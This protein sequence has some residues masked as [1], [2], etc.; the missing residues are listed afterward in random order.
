MQRAPG[1]DV[2]GVPF[3]EEVRLAVWGKAKPSDD[4]NVRYDICGHAMQW[5]RFGMRDLDDV[6]GSRGWE[7]DHI[8]PVEKAGSDDPANL[9]ALW[10]H[11]NQAKGDRFPWSCEMMK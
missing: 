7:I 6:A 3:S 11:T 4:P 2:N 10:W 5:D 1:T 9:Q 8:V